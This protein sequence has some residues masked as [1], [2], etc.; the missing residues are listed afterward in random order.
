MES[1]TYACPECGV[2]SSSDP[3]F[4]S[5]CHTC[6]WRADPDPPI[7]LGGI[8]GWRARRSDREVREEFERC[9]AADDIRAL[10]DRRRGVAVT[11][12]LLVHL[13]T[14]ALVAA[15]VLVAISPLLTLLRVIIAAFLVGLAF[16]V[17][18]RVGKAPRGIEIPE[19]SATVIW[20][21]VR[22]LCDQAGAHTPDRL[23][24][25]GSFN[26]TYGMW[27]LER[28]RY[29]TIGYPLWNVLDAD[30]RI[31]LLAHEVAHDVNGDLRHSLVVGSALDSLQRWGRLLAE[32]G[33]FAP[34]RTSVRSGG[35]QRAAS[36]LELF[37][38]LLVAPLCGLVI[39]A[40]TILRGISARTGQR[41]E[42]LADEMSLSA[43]GSSASLGCL[44]KLL[45]GESCMRELTNASRRREPDL[46]RS[47]R[48]FVESVPDYELARRRRVAGAKLLSIDGRHPPT[49]LRIRFVEKRRLSH[50]IAVGLARRMQD[51]DREL[52][53]V[54]RHFDKSIR[55]AFPSFVAERPVAQGPGSPPAS[56]E[57]DARDCGG[58]QD[59][60]GDQ[61]GEDHRAGS[62][63][64]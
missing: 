17:M 14:F 11:C 9:A 15:A 44:T 13:T 23:F 50:G 8:R 53:P 45:L 3:R 41:A 46:W 10:S 16:E 32:S 26:A 43:A 29:L 38:P 51:V 5:W 60:E 20:S 19:T 52:A 33:S 54:A 27:G 2:V 40:G 59:R 39:I 57:Q 28:R 42:Y 49:E 24:F 18:P 37:V 7:Q 62:A 55:S 6:G 63:A 58:N 1:S 34:R 36:F 35:L 25:D 12:A 21:G 30:E 61:E 4:V 56:A 22:E 64:G 47:E 48:D 31:A